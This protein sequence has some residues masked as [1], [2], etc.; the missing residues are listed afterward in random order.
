MSRSIKDF[1]KK[2]RHLKIPYRE[3]T[4]QLPKPKM[5]SRVMKKPSER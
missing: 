5:P 1:E 4:D 2:G 3:E